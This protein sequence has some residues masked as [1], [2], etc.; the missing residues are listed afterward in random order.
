MG[1]SDQVSIGKV[2]RRNKEK[3]KIG[4][5]LAKRL[6]QVLLV[7]I[8]RFMGIGNGRGNGPVRIDR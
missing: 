5:R 8:G 1:E 4:P 7:R 6:A 3:I 2:V